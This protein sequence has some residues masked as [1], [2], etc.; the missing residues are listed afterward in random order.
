M[1]TNLLLDLLTMPGNCILPGAALSGRYRREADLKTGAFV[2][3]GP[4]S[5]VGETEFL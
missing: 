1:V 5:G 3:V 2:S 4:A